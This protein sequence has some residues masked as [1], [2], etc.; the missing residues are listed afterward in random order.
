[1]KHIYTYLLLLSACVLTPSCNTDGDIQKV[2]SN[3]LG[4]PLF[5]PKKDSIPLEFNNIKESAIQTNDLNNPIFGQLTQG[6][7]GTTNVS[8]VS[9][10]V[11]ST[12]N[13]TFGEKNK[14]EETSSYN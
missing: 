3:I 1:M 14:T 11:L 7:L 5:T 10:V 9:Q 8:I 6:N 12:A 2:G 13:P 4:E